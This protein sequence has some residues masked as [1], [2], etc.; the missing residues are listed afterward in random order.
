MILIVFIIINKIFKFKNCV[1]IIG[2]ITNQK[3]YAPTPIL[4]SGLLTFFQEG[5][6]LWSCNFAFDPK[7]QKKLSG[8]MGVW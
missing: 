6:A 4:I 1:G 2:F 7:S 5:V 8:L 3:G